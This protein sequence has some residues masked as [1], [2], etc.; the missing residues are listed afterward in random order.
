M[1]SNNIFRRYYK[2]VEHKFKKDPKN[3]KFIKD[4]TNDNDNFG[5]NDIFEVFYLYK[6]ITLYLASPNK[7]N[8]NIDIYELKNSKKNVTLYGHT[9]R[10][11]TIKYYIEKATYNEYLISADFNQIVIIWDISKDYNIK[12]KIDTKYNKNS[13]LFSC[14]LVL[15]SNLGYY[16]K[17]N[18]NYTDNYIITSSRNNNLD[19]ANKPDDGTK[20]YSLTNG[21][22]IKIIKNSNELEIFYLLEWY[23]K[24]NRKIY[25]IQLADK[26]IVINNLLED[27]LYCVL[28]KNPESSHYSGFIYNKGDNDYLF[29]SSYNGRI[30][31]WDLYNKKIYQTINLKKS[32]LFHIIKWNAKYIIITDY[33]NKSF[34]IIDLKTNTVVAEI[35]GEYKSAVK[36]IKK[37][38]LGFEEC[39][40]SCGNDNTIK[41]WSTQ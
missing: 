7:S 13:I 11:S 27:E 1:L 41:L 6:D 17:F 30:D 23:N 32:S 2:I 3:L 38:Y 22:F 21:E 31:I 20:I 29:S 4:I 26:K 39:L 15:P 37:V 28:I 33:K 14:L 34:K 9:S 8:Y 24:K 16:S 12:H 19:V 36:C 10:I 5:V 25:I 35:K 40:L 18:Y